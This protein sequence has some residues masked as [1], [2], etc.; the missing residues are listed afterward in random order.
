MFLKNH[1]KDAIVFGDNTISYDSL[2]SESK[3]YSSLTKDFKSDKV[4]IFMENRPEW[5]FAFYSAWINYSTVVTVDFM[6]SADDTSYIVNDCKPEIVFISNETKAV[7]DEV[8]QLLDYKPIIMNVDQ[9]PS[10]SELNT[11]ITFPKFNDDDTLL[12]IYTSGTTGSPKGVMLTLMNIVTNLKAVSDDLPIYTK[13]DRMLVLL[14]LHHIFPLLG[15]IVMPLYVGATIAF[16]PSMAGEDIINTLQKNKITLILGVPRL[17]A[18]IRKGIRDKI[19]KSPVAK[20]LFKLAEKIDSRKF[21]M[22]I[23]GKVHERF[24]GHVK[25]MISGGAALDP[26]VARDFKTLGFEVLEGFGMTEAAPM[27]TFTRPGR[28][29]IGSPGEPLDANEVKIVDGEICAKGPNIMKG[30]YNRPEETAEIL[31]DGWLHT[32]DLGY[33]DEDGFLF[34]TGR[35]KEIIVLQNG[36]NINPE[37]IELKIAEFDLVNEVGVFMDGEQ[38]H[39]VIYPEFSVLHDSG[40]SNIKEE[41]T[42]KVIDAYNKRVT[43][44]K[45]VSK[46]TLINDPLPRTRL[47]K[48]KRFLL[49]ELALK[50]DKTGEESFNEPEFEEYKILKD[51]LVQQKEVSVS[52]NN[53]LEIDLGLD[54]LDKVTLQVFINSTFGMEFKDEHF[55]QYP[56]VEKLAEYITKTKTKTNLES[57]DWSEILKEKIN[58][59]LPKSWVTFSVFKFFTFLAMKTY[60]R[61]NVEGHKQLPEGPVIIAPNHQS[62]FDGLFVTMSL[63]NK[64]FK[65][66]YFYAKEKHVRNKIVKFIA[67]KHNVI[68]MDINKEL[69]QSLQKMAA[70]LEKGKNIIIFP[71]G[72]RSTNGKLGN[73]KKTFAILSRELNVPVVPVSIKGA[74]EALPKGSFIPRPFKK[75]KVKYH[76]PIYPKDH[77]YDTLTEMV[78][79]TVKSEVH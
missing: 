5:V 61:V 76:S 14:P 42:W 16:S 48:L 31:R 34:I 59:K 41:F 47:S 38:L 10:A 40:I 69:K 70:V 43:P 36:K 13:N 26:A 64:F 55:A 44:Y 20:L 17:Y 60:F 53:H 23:F 7:F 72:T 24:G 49:P 28:V 18:I 45:K 22:K 58:L 56:T 32:G 29:R 63:K 37:E 3:N 75:I 57:I 65:K 15:T 2:I 68:V 67:D 77:T 27:I 50:L 39:A 25:N 52:P 11:E 21:S 79:N 78:F 4:A 74:F 9:I 19:N 62:F 6:S 71:E 12:I 66:T 8:L 46:F 54:S 51:F 73:Y 1:D 35:R 30:Y 33:L